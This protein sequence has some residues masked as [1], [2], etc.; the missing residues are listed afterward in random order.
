[1]GHWNEGGISNGI[2]SLVGEKAKRGAGESEGGK[3]KDA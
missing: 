1:M 2:L 3:K